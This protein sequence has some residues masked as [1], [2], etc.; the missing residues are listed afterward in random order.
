MLD[1]V[2]GGAGRY[3]RAAKHI[4]DLTAAKIRTFLF[5]V[6]EGVSTYR[7]MHSLTQQVEHQYHGRFLIELVQNA[8]DAFSSLPNHAEPNRIEIVF[9]ST[10]SEY[11][12]L[13]V[14][15]DGEPFTASNFERLSQL[16][17]SDK[18]PQKS[19][20][21]KGIG[22]RSV[23]EV[24][25]RPEVYS[26]ALKSS[27]CFDG[28]CFA[29]RPEVVQSLV[30]PMVSL[31]GGEGIPISPVSGDS[32]VDWSDGLLKKFR[33]RVRGHD[34]Q[35]LTGETKYLSPYLL[36]VPVSEIVSPAVKAL[37]ARGFE[38]VVRLPLKNN[39]LKDFV[40]GHM[41]NLSSSTVIFLEKVS[42]LSLRVVGGTQQVFERVST[43]FPGNSGGTLVA[44]KDSTLGVRE[45]ALWC[46]NLHVP[47]S[48]PEF[49]LAVSALPGRWP[50]IEDISVSVAVRLGDEPEA[51]RF[52]IYLPTLVAT[53]SAVHVNAPFFGDMS[54]TS[55]PFD[56]AYN[57]Q[58]LQT[59]GDLVLEIVR[60][61][62][63]GK[64]EIEAK[65]IVDLL[66][67]FGSDQA[68]SN[69]WLSLMVDAAVR[70]S[71]SLEEEPLVLAE[72][73]WRA[74]NA[75]SLLPDTSKTSLLTAD[76]LRR[77]ATFDIFHE[78]LSS[79]CEQLKALA[80]ARFSGVGAFPLPSDI[81]STLATIAAALL[82]SDL[83]WNVYWRDVIELL[84]HGQSEL[85]KHAVLLGGDGLLHSATE[86]T[87]V[88]FVPRHGTQDDG[89]V[90]GE[91][92]ATEVPPSLQSTV[93]FLS[94][95]IQLYDAK[96]PT[97]Q[98]PVRSYL[99]NG[100][101]SQFRVESIF[102]GVLQELTPALPVQ[103]GGNGSAICRD[104]LNWALR[105]I[106][107]VVARGRSAEA[108]LKLLRA[109]PVPCH[110]GW[111]PMGEASFGPGWIDTSGPMLSVYLNALHSNGV[112]E[113]LK[114]LL[115][116]PGDP[117]WAGIA[118][119]NLN[120]LKLGGVFD[121]LRLQVVESDA[122]SSSFLASS[123]NFVLPT[124]APPSVSQQMWEAYKVVVE[125]E[126]K[127][128][129]ST[130]HRYV[131]GALYTFPGIA[132][133]AKLPDEARFALSELV[134]LSLPAWGA[135]LSHILISKREGFSNHIPV[136]S[137]LTYFLKFEPWLAVRDL[138]GA[139]W[140][141][142][143]ERWHVPADALAGR[144]RHFAHLRALPAALSRRLDT[145][146]ELANVLQSLGMP[147]FNLLDET[148]NPRLLEALM[149]S[150]G[151]GDAP[152]MNVLL[153]QIRDAWQR[154]RPVVGQPPLKHLVVRR[155]DKRL[156]AVLPTSDAP[157][158]LPDYGGISAELE[159]FDLP[160][161]TV[162]PNDAK[163]LKDWFAAAYGPKVQLTS[164]LKIVPQ[165][166]GVPWTGASSVALADSELGWLIRPL[167][168]LVAFY[169]QMRGIYSDAF[170]QRV[171]LLRVA[172]IAWVPSA[173]I[174]VMRDDHALMTSDM[175]A[176]WDAERDTILATELCR[177]RPAEMSAALAQALERE[178]LELPLKL[179]LG[180]LESI[181]VKP[182][183]VSGMLSQLRISPEQ[184][185]QVVEHLRGDVAHMSRLLLVLVN[186]VWPNT[187]GAV[188]SDARTEE[189][190]VAALASTGMDELE[191]Q[192]ALRAA[193]DSQDIFEFGLKM[194]R[195][196][197]EEASL[198]RWNE[199]L[200][201]Q[202][203]AMLTNKS[204]TMQL[205]ACLEESAGLMK[206]LMAHLIRQ[207]S[208]EPFSTMLATYDALPSAIDLSQTHWEV[209]FAGGI[210]VIANLVQTWIGGTGAAQ[211]VR[212]AES[213][214]SLRVRFKEIG[215]LLELDPD[216]CSRSNHQLVEVVIA[217][218]ERL[219]LAWWLK[220]ANSERQGEWHSA[221]DQ[222]RD[223][224]KERFLCDAFTQVW[225]EQ[226]VFEMLRKGFPLEKF[227]DFHK[228]MANA[229]DIATLQ[230]VLQ[231]SDDQLTDVEA[232]LAARK[233]E[234]LRLRN[235]VKVCGV[236]FD[237][238]ED[239]RL[240]LWK[241]LQTHVKYKELAISHPLDISK[242]TGLQLVKT[243]KVKDRTAAPK[244]P[245][246]KRPRQ[247]KAV[248]ELVGLA[249]EI[250]VYEM[251]Q[252]TYGAEVV[253]SSSWISENSRY[254]FPH[255]PVDDGKGCDF[256]FTVKG[257]PH[258]IEV[259]ATSGDDE[260]FSLGSSEIVL[261][262]ELARKKRGRRDV[263]IIVHVLNALTDKPRA[264]VLPN[265]YETKYAGMFSIETADARVRY[266]PKT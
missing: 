40:L 218:I 42:S 220:T 38:T 127:P 162:Y 259:K 103:I 250:F 41:R 260:V 89:D 134:L 130:H 109:I 237:G 214:E 105:L 243:L 206:R 117:A 67:P 31:A 5:E 142:P 95:K 36:P 28:Y 140:A 219:R 50:E 46:Q 198:G 182:E 107:N 24:S 184:V 133:V 152:D 132:D 85:T 108:T 52:S 249:G 180:H 255:N 84:P 173:E 226:Y 6:A 47:S 183:D 74:L 165:V 80:K 239:N 45:Y 164:K 58:L 224:T 128:S 191:Q 245:T 75:T 9:D 209:D 185:E 160:V 123:S 233:A 139:T 23:L 98:T 19:I 262:M 115:L 159:Q 7:S 167:L 227:A 43:E 186:V 168:A 192:K 33:G 99:G 10:D 235:V 121:G 53:G 179:V 215:V 194:W 212:G 94:E 174:A 261:A 63:S 138:K 39:D 253:S 231:I 79:R 136:T 171:N 77:H 60:N 48:S 244:S 135:G 110:G 122:W 66:C 201:Q 91:G 102:T 88:F 106:G 17:Q 240:H 150:V 86:D 64:G 34:A 125:A 200:A 234:S 97:V 137:L 145:N 199:V 264:V 27:G 111:Y 266:T 252:R 236:E 148:D 51:G 144:A 217:G 175:S 147:Y 265:P 223:S 205:Q 59:A 18:D 204:W 151:S 1:V 49:R 193:R 188:F 232:A 246:K 44:I 169:G 126:K 4:S 155:R 202:G 146:K 73:G 251:L 163:A 92:G 118:A 15:N 190:L 70:A 176:I 119:A 29:F 61:K 241:L 82:E 158:F 113:A 154:F 149:E 71:A 68:A 254:V 248:D 62:L 72:E 208:T 76:L 203:Q 101:V 211:A 177:T 26:R 21:N 11:G 156:V 210:I 12:S 229:T 161:L 120:L 87:M 221:V 172:R 2:T 69:R 13:L 228:T 96:R 54:R 93:A 197:G 100:L 263:F 22:F 56:D 141:R 65:A 81:A 30:A 238:S 166:D 83:D 20:G 78:C 131:V 153:G 222:F 195:V 256:I 143:A 57:R 207:G 3:T 258:R 8:H 114:R 116:A 178:D 230:Q 25:E 124:K 213:P 37:E 157:V 90:G 35:W 112:E 14:A 196:Y 55:I 257:K 170:T 187:D 181:D 32:L 16:G 189:Q 216:E 225:S 129:F 104:I 247:T 242:S